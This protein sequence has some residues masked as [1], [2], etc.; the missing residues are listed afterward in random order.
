MNRRYECRDGVPDIHPGG[1]WKETEMREESAFEKCFTGQ[2]RPTTSAFIAAR[3]VSDAVNERFV[4]DSISCAGGWIVPF[5]DISPL[6]ARAM[7]LA[8]GRSFGVP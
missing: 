6:L 8:T 5:C 7:S 1:V 3:R 4:V 2:L